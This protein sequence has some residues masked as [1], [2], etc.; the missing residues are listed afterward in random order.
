MSTSSIY[1]SHLLN[2]EL[3]LFEFVNCWWLSLSA[4]F[5]GCCFD[6]SVLCKSVRAC[7]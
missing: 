5:A 6:D 4:V 2:S 1:R 3:G 7:I